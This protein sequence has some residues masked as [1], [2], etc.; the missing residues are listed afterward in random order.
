MDRLTQI[1]RNFFIRFEAFFSVLFKSV[2]SFFSNIVGFFA[3]L[4]GYTSSD[5]YLETDTAQT[6]KRGSEEQPK[7][8]NQSTTTE[9]PTAIRRRPKSKVDDY[10]LNMARDVQKR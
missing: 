9:T 7:Q 6:L 2:V 5:Y 1:I 4:F 8:I 3:K 10:Y